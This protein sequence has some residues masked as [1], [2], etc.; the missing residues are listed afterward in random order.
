ME[1]KSYTTPQIL[2]VQLNHEQA[3]LSVCSSG[4]GSISTN[5]PLSSSFCRSGTPICKRYSNASG[6]DDNTGRS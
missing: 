5:S 4:V 2:R 3:V 1:K 6:G